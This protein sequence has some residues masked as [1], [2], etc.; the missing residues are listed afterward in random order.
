MTDWPGPV[1]VLLTSGAAAEKASTADARQA[2]ASES[3]RE[4]NHLRLIQKEAGDRRRR[5]AGLTL[6]GPLS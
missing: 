3:F 5:A 4:Q 2:H 1:A 6:F